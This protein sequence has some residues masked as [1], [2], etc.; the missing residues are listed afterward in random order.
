MLEGKLGEKAFKLYLIDNDICFVEDTTEFYK[1]DEYDFVVTNSDGHKFKVDVKTR[2]KKYHTRTLE[3]VEQAQT[4]PKDIFISARLY[5]YT[6]IKLLDWF[7]YKDMI[8]KNCIEN[9]GYTDNYV[10]YDYD[11]RPMETLYKYIK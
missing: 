11:L 10:M 6:R 4:H 1:R 8:R 9:N 2:T 5:D 3:M 7:L